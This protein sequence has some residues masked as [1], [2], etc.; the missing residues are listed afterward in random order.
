VE[1]PWESNKLN[2]IIYFVEG[3]TDTCAVCI[4]LTKFIEVS[5]DSYK[6]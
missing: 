2:D 6:L 4:A 3:K 5:T 1:Q